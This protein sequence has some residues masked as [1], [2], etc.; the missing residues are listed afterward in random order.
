MNLQIVKKYNM[1]V[2]STFSDT[3]INNLAERFKVLSEP[4]RLK[5]LRSLFDGEKCVT[6]IIELTGLMQANVSKQLKILQK[7]GVVES[8]AE[9]LQRFY[10]VKDFTVLK[11]CNIFCGLG[12]IEIV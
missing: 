11:I 10:C 5:I 1:E 12:S 8:R 6:E 4:S 3:E 2:K 9:G 7:N